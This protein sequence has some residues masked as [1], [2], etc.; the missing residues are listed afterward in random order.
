MAR[1]QDDRS[2]LDRYEPDLGVQQAEWAEWALP[3]RGDDHD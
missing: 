3:P 2:V 1:E